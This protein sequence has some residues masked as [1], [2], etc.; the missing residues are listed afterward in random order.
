MPSPAVRSRS[1]A[2]GRLR[3]PA[4][5]PPSDFGLNG[6]RR[7]LGEAGRLRSSTAISTSQTSTDLLAPAPAHSEELVA[8]SISWRAA[9][10]RRSSRSTPRRVHRRACAT[11]A[12]SYSSRTSRTRLLSSRW[13]DS[14]AHRGMGVAGAGPPGQRISAEATV[15]LTCHSAALEESADR[16]RDL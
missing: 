16:G 3:S 8:M 14:S 13:S 7:R 12:P 11:F 15:V 1:R 4:K 10:S 9:Q 2:E 5:P 6:R